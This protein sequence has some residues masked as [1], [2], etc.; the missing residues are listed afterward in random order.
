M[1]RHA[2]RAGLHS[3]AMWRR[4]ESYQPDRVDPCA[5]ND[6]GNATGKVKVKGNDSLE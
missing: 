5:D 4:H 3:W 2:P 6:D 1:T